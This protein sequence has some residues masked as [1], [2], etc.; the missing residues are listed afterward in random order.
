[1]LPKKNRIP[2]RFFPLVIIKGKNY[3]SFN[4]YIRVATLPSLF[5]LDNQTKQ[6]SSSKDGVF[7][8]FSFITSKK[9]S[10]KAVT[11]NKFRR[12]GY[13][14]VQKNIQNIKEGFLVA[15]FFKKN[16]IN[17]SKKEIEEEMVFLF[18]KANLLK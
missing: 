1:M 2:R 7:S 9:V 5:Y 17:L 11:R 6:T 16:V 13:G 18:K 15:V 3:S 4:M 12:I 8:R 10:K 14:V